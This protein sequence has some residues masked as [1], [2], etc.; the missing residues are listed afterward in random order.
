MDT[1][2]TENTEIYLKPAN[3]YDYI[4]VSVLICVIVMIVIIAGLMI[5]GL[6]WQENEIPA[7]L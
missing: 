2:R 3:I 4:I 6:L 7:V 5:E 1:T